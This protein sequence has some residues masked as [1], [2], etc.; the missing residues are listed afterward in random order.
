MEYRVRPLSTYGG[1]CRGGGCLQKKTRTLKTF[2]PTGLKI[3]KGPSED[4]FNM[5]SGSLMISSCHG[6]AHAAGRGHDNDVGL[7]EP[8]PEED[9]EEFLGPGHRDGSMKVHC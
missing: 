2:N 3:F 7:E 5:N 6:Y 9:S 1:V 8:G 4:V